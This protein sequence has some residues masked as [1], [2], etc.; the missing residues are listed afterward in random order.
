MTRCS[1]RG[2]D[3]IWHKVRFMLLK[4][5][6]RSFDIF[7][8]ISLSALWVVQHLLSK[9]QSTQYRS[10]KIVNF[11]AFTMKYECFTY[12]LI[13]ITTMIWEK[14]PEICQMIFLFD[15]LVSLTNFKKSQPPFQSVP[16]NTG[17]TISGG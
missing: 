8:L 4:I 13:F 7:M 10:N 17:S 1:I 16:G 12:V 14:H 3:S 2:H 15:I 6:S 9:N 5:Q 11:Q